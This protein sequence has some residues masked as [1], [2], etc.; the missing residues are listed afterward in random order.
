VAGRVAA[1]T[2]PVWRPGRDVGE[3]YREY[4]AV[5]LQACPETRIVKVSDFVDNGVGLI[6]T[7][8]PKLRLLADKCA[9]CC[10]VRGN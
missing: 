6:H 7:T 3:Q 1:V 9:R 4:V 8:G 2:N 10:P 5:S